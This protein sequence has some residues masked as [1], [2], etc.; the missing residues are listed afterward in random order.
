VDDSLAALTAQPKPLTIKGRT[1]N[2]YP[3]TLKD[4]GA[5][6]AWAQAQFPD[7]FVVAQRAMDNFNVAQQKLLLATALELASKMKPKLG[8]PEVDG[9][10]QSIDGIKH[11]LYLSISKGDPNFTT[12][13]AE[14]IFDDLGVA[15]IAKVFAA[16][17]VAKVVGSPKDEALTPNG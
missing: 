15:E 5:L 8:T 4:L 10:I 6:E 2:L 1:Y 3:F 13:D 7:P 14:A 17:D 11:V 9:L 12:E 16:T